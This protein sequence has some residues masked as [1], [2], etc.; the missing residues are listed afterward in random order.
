ML[1][2]SILLIYP[3]TLYWNWSKL[4]LNVKDVDPDYLDELLN[5]DDEEEDEEENI[6]FL[7]EEDD[8]GR[9]DY[10]LIF[11]TFNLIFFKVF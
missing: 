5:I 9:I 2:K 10:D 4:R 3:T 8:E 1:Y 6:E 7:S 11:L